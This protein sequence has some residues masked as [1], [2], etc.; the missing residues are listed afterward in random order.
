MQV[1]LQRFALCAFAGATTLHV[2]SPQS[3]KGT[4]K[5]KNGG[6]PAFE[7]GYRTIRRHQ[8]VL[9]LNLDAISPLF[10]NPVPQTWWSQS[11]KPPPNIEIAYAIASPDAPQGQIFTTRNPRRGV[12]EVEGVANAGECPRA[13][14]E[15][16]ACPSNDTDRRIRSPTATTDYGASPHLP[17]PLHL[18][19]YRILGD[20]VGIHRRPQRDRP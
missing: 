13:P 17:Y 4:W 6:T 10:L 5:H 15:T 3:L 16:R 11:L 19:F 8:N 20:A 18:D 1:D 2:Y 12:E 9:L 7:I 14:L